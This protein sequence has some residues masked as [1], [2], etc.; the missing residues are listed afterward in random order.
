MHCKGITAFLFL[1]GDGGK[2]GVKFDAKILKQED[3]ILGVILR[4]IEVG[5]QNCLEG[6]DE[7]HKFN[8]SCLR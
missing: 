7:P 3:R 5:R 4:K 6:G 2:R 8:T 1:A